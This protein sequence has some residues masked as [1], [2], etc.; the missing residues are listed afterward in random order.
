[1]AAALW[2]LFADHPLPAGW[3]VLYTFAVLLVGWSAVLF[4]ARPSVWVVAY[5]AV[6][7]LILP[8][9]VISLAK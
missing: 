6:S 1:M 4:L 2:W 9:V 7:S 5:M 3:V 8:F